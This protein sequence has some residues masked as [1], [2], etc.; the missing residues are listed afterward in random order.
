ME[1]RHIT[2]KDDRTLAYTDCGDPEGIPV[3][4]AHRGQDS[5]FEGK[6]V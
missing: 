2:L 6:K 3:F 1:I 4:H 5:P